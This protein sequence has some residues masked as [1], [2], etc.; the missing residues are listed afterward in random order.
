[1]NHVLNIQTKGVFKKSCLSLALLLG[2]TTMANA[3]VDPLTVSG[4]Q[5]L[6]GGENTSFA[7]LSLFWSN[8]GWGGED[9]YTADIVNN[10]KLEFG[11][12]I[13]RAAI[14][15]GT[16]YSGSLNYDWDANMERLDTVVNAAI[17]EDMYVIIDLHSHNAHSDQ[18][19]AIAFFEEVAAKYGDYDNVIYEIYNEPLSVSWSNDIKPYAET[20]ID[21]IREIDPDN[22]IIVG[23]PTWSQDVDVA[24]EDPIDRDNIAYTLHFYA[25]THGESY[26]NKAQTALDNGIALFVT[27]WGTVNSDGNGG[28]NETE[29]DSWMDFLQS[30]NISH[31][32]WALNDKD[33]GASIFTEG[34]GWDSLTDSGKKVKEIVQGWDSSTSTADST[35]TTESTDTDEEASD[36][37]DSTD[38]TDSTDTEAGTTD[39]VDSTDTV[40]TDVD[41]SSMNTYP[42]WVSADYSGGVYTHNEAGEAMQYNSTA[43]TANWYTN[44]I[45]GSDASW[46]VTGSCS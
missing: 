37:T 1:M 11:A 17:A 9:F 39:T 23:T 13:I 16:D 45:P 12:N 14:G 33:E 36:T 28:V 21:I 46:T 38:A 25:G 24:S 2:M 32:N 15:H 10:A 7:G 30:N 34:G 43:Y 19:T 20:V 29:T 31:A 44:S 41:C 3:A 8:T 27:E 6:A 5:V 35:E 18:A 22:L 40:T 4:N 42:D 26:R